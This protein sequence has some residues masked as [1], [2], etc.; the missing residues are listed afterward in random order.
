MTS[1]EP[2]AGGAKECTDENAEL[3]CNAGADVKEW[4][5]KV[6]SGVAAETEA[7]AT[8]EAEAAAADLDKAAGAEIEVAKGTTGVGAEV[9]AG[10]DSRRGRRVSC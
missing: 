9:D 8:G 7:G 6:N 3:D 2:E 4:E 10:A 1:V 5:G